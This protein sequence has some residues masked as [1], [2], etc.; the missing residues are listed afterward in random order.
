MLM[1]L[2]YDKQ[3]LEDVESYSYK[4]FDKFHL[5]VAAIMT[6]SD[7]DIETDHDDGDDD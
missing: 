2:G 7:N 5:W 4:I 6:M 3:V 1:F